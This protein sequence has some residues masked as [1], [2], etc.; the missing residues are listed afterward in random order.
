MD[1]DVTSKYD[2]VDRLVTPWQTYDFA[3]RPIV[4]VVKINKLISNW[5]IS[6]HFTKWIYLIYCE[7]LEK[8][9]FSEFYPILTGFD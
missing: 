8:T 7:L 2:L 5:A 9:N 1:S 6:Q 4:L 3:I